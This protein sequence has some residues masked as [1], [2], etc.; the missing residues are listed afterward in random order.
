MFYNERLQKLHLCKLDVDILHYASLQV[1]LYRGFTCGGNKIW[2]WRSEANAVCGSREYNASTATQWSYV[3]IAS[4]L[5]QR[6]LINQILYM[7]LTV[8][9]YEILDVLNLLKFP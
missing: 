8:M 3:H 7:S 2:I 9:R 1:M 5:E 4:P 6:L